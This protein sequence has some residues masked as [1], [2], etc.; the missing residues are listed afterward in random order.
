MN[1]LQIAWRNFCHRPLSS[2]LTTLSLLLGVALVVIVVSIYGIVRDTFTNNATVG[3]NL[4]VGPPGSDL[5]LTLNS[6]YYLSEPIENLPYT[7]LMKFMDQSQRAAA[8]ER[9]GGDPALGQVGGEYESYV[10][11]GYAIPLALGDFFGKYRL[12][13]T[14]PEF[15]EKLRYG[16]SVDQEFRFRDG[17]ALETFNE[18]HGYFE[19]VLGHQAAKTMDINIGDVINPS[20]GSPEG[21]EHAEGFT[22]VGILAPTG[23]P[24][25]RAAFVN[26]EGFYLMD[27]HAND[28]DEEDAKITSPVAAEN[29]KLREQ[30][31]YLEL[32]PLTIPERE[33]TAI[34]VKTD[35]MSGPGLLNAVNESRR[36]RAAAPVGAISKLMNLFI[37]PVAYAMMAITLITC[38]VAAVGVLVAIY[39]SMN[40]RRRD[41][42][43]MR[44][45][46][47]RRETVTT[48]IVLE[49]FIV[50]ILG[51]VG[52]WVL[53]HAVIALASPWQE[54]FTGIP[55]SFFSVSWVEIWIAPVVVG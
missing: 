17:R 34:L 5:Q 21:K 26:L 30:G 36:A 54:D 7:Y 40:D 20:H 32:K 14:T 2:I 39:N 11:G 23:T 55:L 29:Q 18:Q 12:V 28:V 46:G 41:I 6:V 24:Q 42:A 51:G 44:A 3:Y 45:L 31:R 49:S 15:F 33:V 27:G 53:A 37:G 22:V 43:V 16:K 48:I 10:A 35:F 25:D 50:A 13:G 52:G 1:L 38:F 19:A 8:V 4:V 47:A 9:C